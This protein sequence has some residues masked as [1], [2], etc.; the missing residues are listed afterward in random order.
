MTHTHTS[1]H[2][3]PSCGFSEAAALVVIL[4]HQHCSLAQLSKGRLKI[5]PQKIDESG[6]TWYSMNH[7]LVQH[8]ALVQRNALLLVH[9]K[10][11]LKINPQKMATIATLR[12]K[13]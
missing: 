9:S 1:N 2:L 12:C 4:V 3:F 5:T 11:R 8:H 6:K 10:R 13:T 7:A